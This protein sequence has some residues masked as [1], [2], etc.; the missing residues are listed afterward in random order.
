MYIKRKTK[1]KNLFMTQVKLDKGTTA[2]GSIPV[3][4]G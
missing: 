4:A 1:T 3:E 2:F